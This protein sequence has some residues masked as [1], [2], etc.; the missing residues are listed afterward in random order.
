MKVSVSTTE[1]EANNIQLSTQE[2][3]FLIKFTYPH[4]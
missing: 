3:T 4:I 1:N 2:M